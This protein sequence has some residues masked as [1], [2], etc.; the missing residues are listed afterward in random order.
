MRWR[1]LPRPRNASSGR[2]SGRSEPTRGR[3]RRR[4]LPRRSPPRARGRRARRRLRR[5]R[6][7]RVRQGRT[8]SARRPHPAGGSR[9]R[10]CPSTMSSRS[11]PGPQADG[12]WAPPAASTFARRPGRVPAARLDRGP[13]GLPQPQDRRGAPRNRPDFRRRP[14]QEP[15]DDRRGRRLDDR[16]HGLPCPGCYDV[17]SGKT[18][19]RD[20]RYHRRRQAGTGRCAAQAGKPHGGVLLGQLHRKEAGGLHVEAP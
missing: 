15:G 17:V 7:D 5:G 2:N 12:S 6:A 3:S 20:L 14:L 1:D 19:R 18:D 11:P 10:L 4:P 8:R 13:T 16:S 9:S